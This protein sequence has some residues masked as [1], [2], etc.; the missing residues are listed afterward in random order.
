MG[1]H[2]P[3]PPEIAKTLVGWKKHFNAYTTQ[4]RFNVSYFLKHYN[5][6]K[7]DKHLFKTQL[8]LFYLKICYFYSD[9]QQLNVFK[10]DILDCYAFARRDRFR[11]SLFLRWQ[12]EG[13]QEINEIIR[14]NQRIQTRDHL[15]I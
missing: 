1:E 9:N 8:Y 2:E 13:R 4:G 15:L 14:K 10:I 12:E 5:R 6:Y 11:R 3:V 7:L